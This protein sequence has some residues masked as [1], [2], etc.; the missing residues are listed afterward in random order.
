[1]IDRQWTVESATLYRKAELIQAN[2]TRHNRLFN[3]QK[4]KHGQPAMARL[5]KA[6]AAV[7]EKIQERYADSASGGA[8]EEHP[9]TQQNY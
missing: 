2:K 9:A 1:M 4:S 5:G 6:L 8:A 7:G 3:G